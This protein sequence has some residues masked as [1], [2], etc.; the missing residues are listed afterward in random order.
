MCM[1]H[2]NCGFRWLLYSETIAIIKI[3]MMRIHLPATVG[4]IGA[5]GW[6]ISGTVDIAM[7]AHVDLRRVDC[8]NNHIMSVDVADCAIVCNAMRLMS[9]QNFVNTLQ[10][11]KSNLGRNKATRNVPAE[12]STLAMS[13]LPLPISATSACTPLEICPPHQW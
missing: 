6:D 2:M 4:C 8:D 13:I 3:T 5:L 11:Y 9:S 7:L 12:I 10:K 1:S